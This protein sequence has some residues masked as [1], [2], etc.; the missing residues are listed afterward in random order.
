MSSIAISQPHPRR[1]LGRAHGDPL[2]S[3]RPQPGSTL[4]IFAKVVE[5]G[6]F[7]G[8]ARTLGLSPSVIS[9]HIA[10]LEGYIGAPLLY[11][12]TRK[13]ALTSDGQKLLE[14][15]SQ[16]IRSAESTL[17]SLAA[18]SAS[19]AGIVHIGADRDV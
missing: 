10:T 8:A 7:R 9:H 1:R 4:A 16:M 14:V 13:L 5:H 15:A 12:S 3:G 11:R 6:S 17:R 19:P 2:G 18:N